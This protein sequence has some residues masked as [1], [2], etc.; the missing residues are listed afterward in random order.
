[1]LGLLREGFLKEFICLREAEKRRFKWRGWRLTLEEK[2]ASLEL[3]DVTLLAWTI[4]RINSPIFF[5]GWW[6]CD[7]LYSSSTLQAWLK[8]SSSL[9][10]GLSAYPLMSFAERSFPS[11]LGW[12][13]NCGQRHIAVSIFLTSP[14]RFHRRWDQ[15]WLVL[16]MADFSGKLYGTISHISAFASL[17]VSFMMCIGSS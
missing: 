12:M 16:V 2:G 7:L 8:W 14:L 13:K 17:T 1:M 3:L 4:L 15:E 9:F 5:K 11:S 10:Q 6:L